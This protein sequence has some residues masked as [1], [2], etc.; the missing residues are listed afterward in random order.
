MKRIKASFPYSF[1]IQTPKGHKLTPFVADDIIAAAIVVACWDSV[2]PPQAG[3]VVN[4]WGLDVATRLW[5][6]GVINRWGL[7]VA[8]ARCHLLSAPLLQP[9]NSRPWSEVLA[10]IFLCFVTS[11]LF[12]FPLKSKHSYSN[13]W[14][15]S[16]RC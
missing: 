16:I 1:Q 10:N 14:P 2:F 3:G 6:C 15:S 12:F 5:S 13:L 8:M 4:W 7:D 11:G 9:A